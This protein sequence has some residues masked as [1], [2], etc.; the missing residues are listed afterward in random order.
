MNNELQEIKNLVSEFE[1]KLQAIKDKYSEPEPEFKDG[2][3]YWSIDDLGLVERYRWDG[4][5][6][7]RKMFKIGNVF[8]TEE[9]AE[10]ML[11]KLKVIQELKQMAR[12]FKAG[13]ENFLIEFDHLNMDFIIILFHK[14]QP[15]YDDFYFNTEEEAQQAIKEIGENRIKKYI[16][17][18]VD[19]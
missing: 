13:S 19:E 8:K 3:S 15:A 2:D 11:E 12:P 14:W 6:F 17:G 18:V 9:E 16:F 5:L 1:G 10:F 7:D 4:G